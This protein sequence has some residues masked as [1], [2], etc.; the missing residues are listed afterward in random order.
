MTTSDPQLMTI[1][2]FARVTGLTASALRFYADSGLLLPADI[3]GISGYRRYVPD[4]VARARLLRRLRE[5]ATPLSTAADILDAAPAE[6]AQLVDDHVRQLSEDATLA[7]DRGA[8]IIADLVD[9]RGGAPV[10]VRG[11]VLAAAV[12]KVLT[13]T[14]DDRQHTILNTVRIES[15]CTTGTLTLVATDRVRL[16]IRTLAVSDAGDTSWAATVSVDDLR[17]HLATI[18]RCPTLTIEHM[19][20]RITFTCGDNQLHCRT[21]MEPYPDYQLM[22]SGL[23]DPTTF[24]IVS[25]TALRR[26]LEIL[27][28]DHIT[29]AIADANLSVAPARGTTPPV[30]LPAT[31]HGT[32]MTIGFAL[33]TLYPAVATALG[34]DLLLDLRAPDLPVTV[35]S[36]DE[37]DLITLVMPVD[38]TAVDP[39]R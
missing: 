13:A 31:V 12:D 14:V 28:A 20:A 26:T 34:D 25:G 10:S 37:G 36:A 5:I 7:R 29:M 11:P 21:T 19:T 24:V 9:S 1:G 16:A 2:E 17:S 4:Q 3:D 8:R 32:P 22:L 23:P 39:M 27:D 33:T 35:R 30:V 18:R 15:D 6:A 38:L